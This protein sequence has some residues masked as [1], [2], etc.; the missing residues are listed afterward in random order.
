MNC[1]ASY[2]LELQQMRIVERKEL[3]LKE[4]ILVAGLPDMGNVAGIGMNHLVKA[5]SADLVAEIE[6]D[7]PPYVV[8]KGGLA[9][10]SRSSYKF[11]SAGMLVF[12][13]E[14]QPP[15]SPRLYELCNHVLGYAE[16]LG[17]RQV[18]TIGAAYTEGLNEEPRVFGV[19]NKKDLIPVLEK[20]Q[21]LELEGEGRITG[22]NGLLMGLGTERGLDSICLLGEIDNPHI[23][24]PGAARRIL[25]TLGKILSIQIDVAE[26]VEQEKRIREH[27]KERLEHGGIREP[28]PER[29]QHYVA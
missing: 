25:E 21:I 23:K 4:P 3:K 1:Y 14:F 19:V 8:H 5:L 28:K 2:C 12:S 18:F 29:P 10:F 16:K 26:L 24:Q 15:S 20:Y 22:F 13:G 7:F 27:L 17:V 11:H 9:E 6:A